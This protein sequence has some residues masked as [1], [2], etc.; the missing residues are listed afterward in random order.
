MTL[1]GT[2]PDLSHDLADSLSQWS[3]PLSL[4]TDTKT[5][6]GVTQAK[7]TRPALI[8]ELHNS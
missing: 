8:T 1:I 6:Q 3:E 5:Q 2:W 7:H 4:C